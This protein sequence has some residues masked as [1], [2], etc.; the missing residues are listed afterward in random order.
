MSP[1]VRAD[2]VHPRLQLG[3]ITRPLNFTVR[4]H[5]RVAMRAAFVSLA[6]IALV[7]AE[8]RGDESSIG[9]PT[10]DAALDA[11]HRDPRA[12][13]SIQGGWT[14]VATEEN[15]NHVLWSF[16][17]KGHAAY[18]AAVKRTVLDKDGAVSLDMKV[19]CFGTQ[20]ACDKLVD[21]FKGL[22]ERIKQDMH[23]HG[24]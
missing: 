13:F 10:V 7:G 17:P 23:H 14:I 15:G 1:R 19:L 4:C 5:G 20:A 24:P 12:Q 21:E 22:N 3:G 16:T 9:Y 2:S 8:V 6:V 11:L 18:P